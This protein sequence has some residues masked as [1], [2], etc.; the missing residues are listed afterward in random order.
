MSDYFL[1]LKTTTHF[2]CVKGTF[3]CDA[4][5]RLSF[6]LD[7]QWVAP[8]LRINA[9][10]PDIFLCI[11][12]DLRVPS[13]VYYVSA[14]LLSVWHP[15]QQQWMNKCLEGAGDT[16]SFCH[17]YF[18]TLFG[19]EWMIFMEIARYVWSLE[20]LNTASKVYKLFCTTLQLLYAEAIEAANVLLFRCYLLHSQKGFQ[21]H[22][23]WFTTSHKWGTEVQS[24][25]L[26]I[27][28][29]KRRLLRQADAA[30]G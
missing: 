10:V 2:R 8:L 30:A 7:V 19:I 16:D 24:R 4:K 23:T 25:H 14:F 13:I 15:K 3:L 1:F 17:F 29:L 12:E 18:C 6:Q 9:N 27:A 22:L 5:N 26:L 28:A 20:Y 11:F 21:L